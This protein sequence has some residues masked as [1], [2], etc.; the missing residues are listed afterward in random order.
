MDGGSVGVGWAPRRCEVGAPWVCSGSRGCG[1]GWGPLRCVT[2]AIGVGWDGGPL[3][4]GWGPH[5]WGLGVRECGV[6]AMGVGRGPVGVGVPRGCGWGVQRGGCAEA[7]CWGAADLLRGKGRMS[8][9]SK[10]TL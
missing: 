1:V 7:T 5:G 2:G 9:K 8:L 3:G 6:R 10:A 4:V